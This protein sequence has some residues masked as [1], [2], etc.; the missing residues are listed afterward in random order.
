MVWHGRGLLSSLLA[1]TD[2]RD[3]GREVRP[4]SSRARL[5]LSRWML[6]DADTDPMPRAGW[7]DHTGDSRGHIAAVTGVPGS[8]RREGRRRDEGPSAATS[9]GRACDVSGRDAGG[10]R[11]D[12]RVCHRPAA[13][14][15]DRATDR[16]VARTRSRDVPG[17]GYRR[18]CECVA[19][20]SGWFGCAGGRPLEHNPKT[21]RDVGSAVAGVECKGAHPRAGTR[22]TDRSGPWR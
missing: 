2:M 7:V 11:V 14:R 5:A 17:I 12:P 21:D 15:A 3:S 9:R 1:A 13:N 22:P 20:T 19:W 10:R 18:A 8:A 4:G 6:G 16:R